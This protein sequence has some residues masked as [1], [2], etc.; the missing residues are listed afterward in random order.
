[1]IRYHCGRGNLEV[2]GLGA[3]LRPGQMS[4]LGNGLVRLCIMSGNLLTS[5]PHDLFFFFDAD[6]LERS[7]ASI[8]IVVKTGACR[9]Q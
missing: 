7:K 8:N 2:L 6:N 4:K 1:M 3:G 5:F 9:W